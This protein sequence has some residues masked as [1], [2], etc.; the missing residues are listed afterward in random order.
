MSK[1]CRLEAMFTGEDGGVILEAIRAC[2]RRIDSQK[3]ALDDFYARIR[4]Q[5]WYHYL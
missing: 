5:D 4:A 3:N 2:N 1:I